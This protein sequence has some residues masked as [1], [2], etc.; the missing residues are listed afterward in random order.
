M[1]DGV[2]QGDVQR[3]RHDRTV[4]RAAHVV[5]DVLLTG[6]PAQ[7]PDDEEIGSEAHLVDDAQL[8][9]EA[10]ADLR[11]AGAFPVPELQALLA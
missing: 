9:I 11:A 4:P 6:K 1:L 5:P 7:V 10:G 2:Q 8:I 3:E